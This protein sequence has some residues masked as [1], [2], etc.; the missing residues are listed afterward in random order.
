V[1]LETHITDIE[2]VIKWE[3]LV[4]HSYGGNVITGV[5]EQVEPAIRSIVFLDAFVPEDG[6][7]PQ[8][9]IVVDAIREAKTRGESGIKPPPI[10][11][12][13]NDEQSNAWLGES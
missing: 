4:G 6:P 9:Q 1:N 13:Q 11:F 10:K 8:A 3:H 12:F 5:A 7:L 2:N